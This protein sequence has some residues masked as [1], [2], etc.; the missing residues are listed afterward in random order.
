MKSIEA[1]TAKVA[2]LETKGASRSAAIAAQEKEG[3]EY[4][5]LRDDVTALQKQLDQELADLDAA[6]SKAT[7]TA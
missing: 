5:S 6:A 4:S 1:L 7:V 2:E 3:A